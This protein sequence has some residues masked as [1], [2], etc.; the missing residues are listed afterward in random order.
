MKYDKIRQRMNMRV[1]DFSNWD[2]DTNPYFKLLPYGLINLHI[3]ARLVVKNSDL[4]GNRVLTKIKDIF[5]LDA[6]RFGPTT[7]EESKDHKSVII[8]SEYRIKSPK[9]LKE[10]MNIINKFTNE[11]NIKSYIYTARVIMYSYPE[12]KAIYIIWERVDF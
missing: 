6:I 12:E 9:D 5:D 4:I 7:S 2:V 8:Q 1:A 3:H 11:Y 10:F